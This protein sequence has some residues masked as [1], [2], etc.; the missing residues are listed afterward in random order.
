[1]QM[2]SGSRSGKRAIQKRC[3]ASSNVLCK[4]RELTVPSQRRYILFT[5]TSHQPNLTTHRLRHQIHQPLSH[6]MRLGP[7]HNFRPPELSPKIVLVGSH[8][9]P[10]T[11]E[12]IRCA[13]NSRSKADARF[14][15]CVRQERRESARIVSKSRS[16]GVDIGA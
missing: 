14:V 4:F 10:R 12:D 15:C 16:L 5:Q 1:M 7:A 11:E 9:R 2:I 13:I 3:T 6:V 8:L